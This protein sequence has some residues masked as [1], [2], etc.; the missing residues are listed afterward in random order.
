MS[1]PLCK[2]GNR[3][4]LRRP[5]TGSTH[6]CTIRFKTELCPKSEIEIPAF[7]S[8]SVLVAQLCPTHC[9]PMG[10]GLPGSSIHGIFQAR[11]LEWLAIPFSR[12]SSWPR[13][14]TPVSHIVGRHFTIW[15]TMFPLYSYKKN[16][17]M[18]IGAEAAMSWPHIKNEENSHA[19]RKAKEK[20]RRILSHC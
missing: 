2:S 4:M 8:V 18:I 14:R 7:F 15:A 1:C 5:E 11:I 16:F 9:D 17:N 13:D 12:G 3:F 10:W 20:G 6:N 19:L